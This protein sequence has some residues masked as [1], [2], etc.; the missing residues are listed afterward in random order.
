MM[1]GFGTEIVKYIDKRTSVNLAN[2]ANNNQ[3]IINKTLLSLILA[4]Q[5]ETQRIQHQISFGM[6]LVDMIKSRQLGLEERIKNVESQNNIQQR[7]L[8]DLINARSYWDTLSSTGSFLAC[9]WIMQRKFVC[10]PI[11]M[12]ARLL[13][14][15][16]SSR[17]WSENAFQLM[18]VY[19]LLRKL[20]GEAGETKY[21]GVG[22]VL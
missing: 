14:R 8:M 2:N 7:Q 18:G 5:K 11:K 19:I 21:G 9:V 15:S 22:L 20:R 16:R 13:F 6:K 17:R 10:L 4:N 12:I 3:S 1:S